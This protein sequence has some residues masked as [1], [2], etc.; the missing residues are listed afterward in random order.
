[1]HT[2]A[3]ASD[4]MREQCNGKALYAVRASPQ[5]PIMVYGPKKI[6]QENVFGGTQSTLF[7]QLTF[8]VS[9]KQMPTLPESRLGAE[10][11]QMPC[12]GDQVLIDMPA[13]LEACVRKNRF[14]PIASVFTAIHPTDLSAILATS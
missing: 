5:L 2:H 3:E 12:V 6:I 11:R 13:E 4:R 1:M 7:Y 10:Q 8:F 14:V 9:L